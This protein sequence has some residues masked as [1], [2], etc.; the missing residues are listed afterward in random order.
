MPE[1]IFFAQNDFMTEYHINSTQIY[2]KMVLRVK[3]QSLKG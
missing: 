3:Q 1:M 2:N